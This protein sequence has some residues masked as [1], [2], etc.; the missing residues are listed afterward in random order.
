MKRPRIK[1]KSNK[2]SGYEDKVAEN[3]DKL[4]IKYGYEDVT[5]PYTI[6]RK[7]K[8]DFSIESGI[9]IESKGYFLSSDRTKHLKIKEQ[10]PELDIRFLFQADNWLTKKHKSRYSDWCKRHEF[11]YHVSPT[12]N[13]PKKWLKEIQN[14]NKKTN[15]KNTKQK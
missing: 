9:L 2:R 12:G 10:H 14:A 15:G 13:L 6:E 11:K 7:Y 3:L 5:I 8:L 4:N 1:L